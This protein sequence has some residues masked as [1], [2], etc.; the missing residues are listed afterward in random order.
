MT[1]GGVWQ[2]ENIED[3]NEQIVVRR[4]WDLQPALSLELASCAS[5]Q[6]ERHVA[7]PVR[8]GHLDLGY[9]QHQAIVEERPATFLD[10]VELGQEVRQLFRI[11]VVD[12]LERLGLKTAIVLIAVMMVF[13]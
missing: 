2:P 7:L 6:D 4:R 12:N 10:R 9:G 8:F 3:R 13:E 5:R 11:E 1:E